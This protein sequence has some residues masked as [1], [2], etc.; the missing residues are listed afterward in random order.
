MSGRA[1]EIMQKKGFIKAEMDKVFTM[2]Q[3]DKL[4][5]DATIKLS[6]FLEKYE[7]R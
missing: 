2:D 3:S 5:T 1:E 4:W 7:Y 6:E